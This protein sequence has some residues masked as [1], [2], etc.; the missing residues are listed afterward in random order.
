MKKPFILFDFDGVIAD[1][2]KLSFEIAKMIC[3]HITEDIYQKRFE[4]NIND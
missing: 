1:S 2:F 4:G 3:P